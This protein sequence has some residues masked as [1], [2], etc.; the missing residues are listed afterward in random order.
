PNHQPLSLHDALPILLKATVIT[1]V[2]PARNIITLNS[3]I[4][5]CFPIFSK[6]GI[7]ESR[8]L[9]GREIAN[10]IK[11]S[12]EKIIIPDNKNTNIEILMLMRNKKKTVPKHVVVFVI[13]ELLLS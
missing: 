7:I 10:T 4:M 3:F 11:S 5:A 8:K 9:I 1:N 6:L 12:W 2:I 13:V